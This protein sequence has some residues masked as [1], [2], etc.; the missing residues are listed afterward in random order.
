MHTAVKIE[1][2]MVAA[3]MGVRLKISGCSGRTCGR[4]YWD[5][6]PTNQDERLPEKL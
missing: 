2:T 1:T 4:R 6:A 5:N 3:R